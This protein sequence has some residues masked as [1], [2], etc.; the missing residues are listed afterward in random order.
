ML[1]DLLL[2]S[3]SLSGDI[4]IT[5]SYAYF[6]VGVLQMHVEKKSM[7]DFTCL[8]FRDVFVNGLP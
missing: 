7:F 8:A 3:F 5:L 1:L 6:M 2:H 4:Y